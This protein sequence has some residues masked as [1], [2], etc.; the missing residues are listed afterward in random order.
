MARDSRP[1]VRLVMPEVR[2]ASTA[3][4]LASVVMSI[5][6]WV[7]SNGT[8]VSLY[9]IPAD[10]LTRLALWQPFTWLLASIGAMPVLFSALIIWSIGGSIERRWGR[11]RF[12][13]FALGTT[14]FAG[15]GAVGIA[16][17]VPGMLG[18]P[19]Q[20]GSTMSSTIWVAWGLIIWNEQT[21]LFGFPLT[22]RTF[23]MIG[24]LIPLLNGVFGGL[25]LMVP[26]YLGII[27]AFIIIRGELSPSDLWVRFQSARL[28]RELKKR[29]S[30]LSVI[31]GGERNMPK[32]SDKYMH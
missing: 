29:S 30:R 3:L 18:L 11:N 9:L 6:W 22:G 23:A 1:Q 27:L 21:N 20:G 26:D 12:L 15:L 25:L 7:L 13:R 8:G 4:A 14:F 5:I 28:Q 10:V 2:N 16:A 31:T 32:D 19:Y 17:L 24:V